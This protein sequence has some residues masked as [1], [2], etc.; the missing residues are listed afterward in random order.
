MQIFT[1][2][3]PYKIASMIKT[4]KTLFAVTISLLIGSA[5]IYAQSSP[6]IS[7]DSRL[8]ILLD[9]KEKLERENRLSSGF[10][11][12]IHNGNLERA[13]KRKQEYEGL[14]ENWPAYIH[15]ETPNYKLWVGNFGTRLEADRALLKLKDL[16][17]SA[18]VLKPDR[19]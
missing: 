5:S 9:L 19:K 17:P 8:E 1:Y 14:G 13:R 18:F 16:F 10:T 4:T 3:Y 7:Q 15:Y 12:Q 2:F 6:E 11:V